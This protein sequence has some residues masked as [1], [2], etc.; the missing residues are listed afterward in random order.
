ME[1]INEILEY[2][3]GQDT[4]DKEV[5]DKKSALWWGKKAGNDMEIRQRFGD[6]HGL[7][8]S[9]VL[10][11]WTEHAPGRLAY[12]ILADQFS[13]TIY[14]HHAA[15]F[16]H[17]KRALKLALEGIEN[18]LDREL[19]RVERVF[20]YM[21]LEHDESPEIQDRSVALFR[22]LAGAAP[23]AEKKAFEN[24]LDFAVRHKQVIDRFGRFPHRNEALGRVSTAEELAF[25]KQP[26]SSF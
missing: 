13:R 5:I 11:I 26:G 4:G 21:P 15:A 12:I 8:E 1:N 3:F 19:R 16:Q 9:G 7:L 14:R 2:W 17:D 10:D 24:F 18:G 22:E 6:L 23:P 25:L 20:F